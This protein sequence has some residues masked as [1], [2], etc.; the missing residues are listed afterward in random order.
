MQD[1]NKG[2]NGYSMS[3]RAAAAYDNDEMPLSKWTKKALLEAIERAADGCDRTPLAEVYKLKRDELR[4]RFLVYTAWHHTSKACNI[5]DFYTLDTN[6]VMR[7]SRAL[8]DEEIQERASAFYNELQEKKAQ[9]LKKLKRAKS[10][11][12]ESISAL[13]FYERNGYEL[14]SVM[15]LIAS[16]CIEWT[17]RISKK[18]NEMIEVNGSRG[19]RVYDFKDIATKNYPNNW[20]FMKVE[21]ANGTPAGLEELEEYKEFNKVGYKITALVKELEQIQER[22]N[23]LTNK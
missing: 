5:T 19:V 8:T 15:H 3:K 7:A 14:N 20:D 17:T 21:S 13:E 9:E 6:E 23:K 2:Y 16:G 11:I 10:E 22:I 4:E 12:I 18:G 1:M